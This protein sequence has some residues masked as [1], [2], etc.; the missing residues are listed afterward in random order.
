ME[1]A[2]YYRVLPSARYPAQHTS[3]FTTNTNTNTN[4][5]ANANGYD[6]IFYIFIAFFTLVA[7]VF[8]PENICKNS[9]DNNC[10]MYMR[11]AFCFGGICFLFL[12]ISCFGYYR[13]HS[14][15]MAYVTHVAETQRRTSFLS[16]IEEGQG[17]NGD[18]VDDNPDGRRDSISEEVDRFK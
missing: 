12:M 4:T 10:I 11:I 6:I 3:N 5:N 17:Q 2:G 7:T 1:N 18:S 15:Y 8:F 16:S 14:A 9:D 13:E